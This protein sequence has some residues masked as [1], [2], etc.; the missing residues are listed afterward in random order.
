MPDTDH[1]A[2][3][4]SHHEGPVPIFLRFLAFGARAFG[5]PVVQIQALL[6]EFVQKRNWTDEARFRRALGVYQVLPGPEAHEMCC[7]LGTVRGGRLGGIAAGLGFMLPGL[8]LMLAASAI[9]A[10]LDLAS[11]PVAGAMAAMQIVACGLIVRAVFKLVAPIWTAASDTNKMPMVVFFIASIASTYL[12]VGAIDGAAVGRAASE[13]TRTAGALFGHGLVAGLVTFGGAYTAL[14]YVTS[15]AAGDGGWMTHQACLDG[16]AIASVLPAPLVIFGTFVGYRGGGIGGALAFTAGIFLP[17]F[18]FTFLGFGLFE[19]LVGWKPA[20]R[21]LDFLS[22]IAVGM[23]AS[24]AILFMIET[25]GGWPKRPVFF[26]GWTAPLIG[27]AIG[28]VFRVK[29]PLGT[30]LVVIGAGAAG[31][32]YGALFG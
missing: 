1:L 22:A 19:R 9:Y 25:G 21:A 5:G 29:H 8:V 6:E 26:G 7:Y 11:P 4:H 27:L 14:P 15:V 30:P 32:A 17:A 24:A 16:I 13:E 28:I 23:I 18:G 10:V 20:R 31:A 12:L 2:E 3:P